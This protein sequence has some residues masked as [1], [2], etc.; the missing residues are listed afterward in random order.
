[1]GQRAA[2]LE[3]FEQEIP[4]AAY[5][6]PLAPVPGSPDGAIR[7]FFISRTEVP[8]E[9]FDVFIYRLDEQRA[10][11]PKGADAV[12]RPSKPYLPPDRG[13]GHEGFPAISMSHKNATE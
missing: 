6:I 7:P 4:V 12:T 8:W 9:A 11:A 5:R 13:F 10:K 1:M 3:P 2:V